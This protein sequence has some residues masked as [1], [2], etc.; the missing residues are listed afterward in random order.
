MFAE[1]GAVDQEVLLS[2]VRNVDMDT[3]NSFYLLI[4]LYKNGGCSVVT[5]L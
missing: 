5:T 4:A 1:D 3:V 2:A